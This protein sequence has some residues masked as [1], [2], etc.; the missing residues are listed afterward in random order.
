MNKFI[1]NGCK[2]TCKSSNKYD[3]KINLRLILPLLQKRKSAYIRDGPDSLTE[4]ITKLE[5]KKQYNHK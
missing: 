3:Y 1:T 5:G 4:N 2:P